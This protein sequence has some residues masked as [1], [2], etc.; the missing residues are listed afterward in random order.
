ML[1]LENKNELSL[2]N[3]QRFD[4]NNWDELKERI[5]YKLVSNRV[6]HASDNIDNIV[7]EDCLDLSKVY[8]VTELS[9]DRNNILSYVLKKQ[10][11]EKFNKDMNDLH[12]QMNINLSRDRI[13]RIH[14]IKDDALSRE[15]LYPLLKKRDIVALNGANILIEESTDYKDNVLFVTNKYHV[16]GT[17]YM[18]DPNTLQEI[19]NRMGNDFYIIPTSVHQFMCV[20]KNYV[21]KNKDMY[22][23]EDDLLDMLYK[24]NSENKSLEDILSYKIYQYIHDDGQ[25]LL[26]IKQNL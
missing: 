23:A 3:F 24:I 10:D 11:L 15:I 18:T 25:V 14:T 17:S 12:K 9:Q 22:E 2:D 13:K 26:P 21:T 4:V 8:I 7:Y 6:F 20:S 1:F 16:F 5:P 19:Y